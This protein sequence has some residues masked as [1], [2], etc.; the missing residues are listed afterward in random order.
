MKKRWFSLLPLGLA[1]LLGCMLTVLFMETF[2]AS[3]EFDRQIRDEAKSCT[4]MLVYVAENYL[5]N[6]DLAG[7]ETFCREKLPKLTRLETR[8]TLLNVRGDVLV[9]SWKDAADMEN[10]GNRPE[11]SI[12]DDSL[13]EGEPY[14][15]VLRY[16]T[17]A[18]QEMFYC[19]T[20]FTVKETPYFLRCAIPKR[21]LD[22]RV[23][24]L[25]QAL[26][27]LLLFAVGLAGGLAWILYRWLAMPSMKLLAAA[28]AIADGKLE[29][30]LPVARH[31]VLREMTSSVH[32]MTERLQEQIRQ[33]TREKRVRDAIFASLDEGVILL[34]RQG[35]IRD[36]NL[37]ACAILDIRP[38]GAMHHPLS[39]IWRDRHW[40][41]FFETR[42]SDEPLNLK[43]AMTLD[44]PLG[45]RE[46]QLQVQSIQWDAEHTGFLMVLYDRTALAK[47]ENYRRDFVANVSH[48]IK[49]PLTVIMG[50]V[51]TL[52]GG[53][54]D[55]P[56]MA[57]K[58][59]ETLDTHARRLH[60]LLEDVLSLSNLECST[61]RDTLPMEN[62]SLAETAELAYA[63]C[64][65]AAATR[66]IRLEF[67]ATES[68]ACVVSHVP[69]MMEQVFVNLLDNAMKYS[70]QGSV[71]ELVVSH[72]PS[73]GTV[74][75]QVNDHGIGIPQVSISRIFE[76]FYRVDPSRSKATGG[77]GL[78]LSIVKHIVQLHDGKIHVE[79]TP[80]EGTR[81]TLVFPAANTARIDN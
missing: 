42:T 2:H 71:V 10:H 45:T 53:A 18:Q 38:V 78:G 44:V 52:L 81:F 22:A 32:A 35:I 57:K 63:L 8:V 21:S 33:I 75:A 26:M 55:D 54:L 31:G 5:A 24:E 3:R 65:P 59:L 36:I 49:T 27:V 41:D 80:E 40:M 73:N 14:S 62:R 9:D 30:P 60:T 34:D 69:A 6:D 43:K 66:N 50:T 1:I 47:L 37:A 15:V 7:L 51:D 70:P 25:H 17:T 68:E 77:T 16:S 19:M 23:G 28:R 58:F 46:V 61:R 4:G 48:E 67:H 64:L 39:E 56:E 76:R 74:T 29:T 13:P 72:D 20:R 79:S 11:F 12:E